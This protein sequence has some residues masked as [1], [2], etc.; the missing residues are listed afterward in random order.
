MSKG[1]KK[2]KREAALPPDEIGRA[3][4]AAFLAAYALCGNITQAAQSAGVARQS[5][6]EWIEGKEYADAFAKAGE[7]ATDRLEAEARRRA[8]R[9]VMRKKFDKGVPVLDPETGAQY[10]E[11]EYS[12]TL[13]IFLLK[14]LRPDKYRDNIAIQ[15]DG[16][17]RTIADGRTAAT[18]LADSIAERLGVKRGGTAGGSAAP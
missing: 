7:E 1:G 6:Y 3:K 13:M 2:S 11:Y 5:H 9:G 4:K 12:D 14:G 8:E 17:L 15:H 18:E 10:V 16:T